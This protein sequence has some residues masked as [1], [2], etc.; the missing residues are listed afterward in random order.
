MVLG[1]SVCLSV[2][3]C[4]IGVQ[5][6]DK[7]LRAGA[8]SAGSTEDELEAVL[9]KVMTLFRYINGKDVFQAFYREDLAKRLLLGKSASVDSEKLMIEKIKA[10]CGGAFTSKLEGM[11]QD[12]ELSK[13]LASNFEA[14]LKEK[15]SKGVVTNKPVTEPEFFRAQVLTSG[16]WPDYKAVA[17]PLPPEVKWYQEVN[18][19][20]TLFVVFWFDTDRLIVCFVMKLNR[21]WNGMVCGVVVWCMVYGGVRIG[22]QSN[23]HNEIQRSSIGVAEFVGDR[24]IT[25]EFSQ[26]TTNAHRIWISS[27]CALSV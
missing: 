6:V 16:A 12:I 4:H 26:G 1:L 22:I 23:V 15:E 11:F 20:S 27:R 2:C 7:K 9:N 13:E 19:Y 10:E 17:I 14:D 24:R 21:F 18:K 5:F 8:G 3:L 25:R